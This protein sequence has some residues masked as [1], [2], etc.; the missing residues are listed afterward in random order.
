[1]VRILNECCDCATD[2]Y[3][4]QGEYCSRRRVEHFYC[5]ACGDE[6]KLYYYDGKQLCIDCVEN[7]LEYVE[8]S[9]NA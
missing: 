9:E 2:G 5:D 6:T 8:G 1:M 3:R 7:E 4:C